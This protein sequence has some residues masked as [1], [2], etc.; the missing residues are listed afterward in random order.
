MEICFNVSEVN[1]FMGWVQSTY[2]VVK[3]IL[4]VLAFI[5]T[6]SGVIFAIYQYQKRFDREHENYLIK[7]KRDILSS[8]TALKKGF[9][10]CFPIAHQ[11]PEKAWDKIS[12]LQ[13]ALFDDIECYYS[14]L[15][16]EERNRLKK[17]AQYEIS[18]LARDE[19][20]EDCLQEVK[21]LRGAIASY[22][23]TIKNGGYPLYAAYSIPITALSPDTEITKRYQDKIAKD[24][25]G[26]DSIDLLDV[27]KD[28][29]EQSINK[30]SVN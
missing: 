13:M 5:T 20:V 24:D 4:E 27:V 1:F 22:Y 2:L 12:R 16:K 23:L 21:I 11:S 25:F 7:S 8:M 6:I 28:L 26:Q 9:G 19:T 18:T 17:H 3:E 10:I 15:S 30:L 14:L 29:F